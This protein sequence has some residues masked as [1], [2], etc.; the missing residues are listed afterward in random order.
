M[1]STI[2]SHRKSVPLVNFFSN[3]IGKDFYFQEINLFH[4]LQ[5]KVKT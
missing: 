4:E 2:G 5:L 1:K 3:L